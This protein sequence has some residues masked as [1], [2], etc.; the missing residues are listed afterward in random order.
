MLKKANL[1]L[2][3]CAAILLT[4]CFGELFAPNK[5]YTSLY[6]VLENNTSN[7]ECVGDSTDVN[8][9]VSNPKA[10]TA[11]SVTV[12]VPDQ[13]QKFI[14]I[15]VQYGEQLNVK[16]TAANDSTNVLDSKSLTVKYVRG[17]NDPPSP[18]IGYCK[19]KGIAFQF[20]E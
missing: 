17:W 18:R 16:V 14:Q 19:G 12:F 2:I 6:V 7:L 3:L 4:S 8:I 20:L 5:D 9:T 1:L 13:T 15:E 10:A 11:K